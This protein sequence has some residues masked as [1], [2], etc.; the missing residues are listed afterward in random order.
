[1]AAKASIKPDVQ[2]E[3]AT[4]CPRLNRQAFF[5]GC[6]DLR[7]G[8]CAGFARLPEH[9][10]NLGHVRQRGAYQRNWLFAMF[11]HWQY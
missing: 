4:A 2:L 6:N 8:H 9:L 11:I 7:G 1:M 5:K 10:Q 3:T